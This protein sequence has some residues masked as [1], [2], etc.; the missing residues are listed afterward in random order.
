MIWYRWGDA[1]DQWLG[2]DKLWHFL[3]AYVLE[4]GLLLIARDARVADVVTAGASFAVEA[5]ESCNYRT[6][7]R[8]QRVG[9]ERGFWPWLTDKASPKDLVADCL[10]LLAARLTWLLLAC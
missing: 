2:L 6:W 1:Q 4:L 7:L 8:F 5:V 10:G 9:I 3:G